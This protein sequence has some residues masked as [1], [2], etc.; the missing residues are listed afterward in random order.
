MPGIMA[1]DAPPLPILLIP[2]PRLRARTRPVGPVDAGK[3]RDLSDRMLDA[4]YKAPGIG[5]AA[6]QVGESLRLIVVD[7]QPDDTRQPYVM[8]NPEIVEA[9]REVALREEGCLSIPNQYA[10]VERPA[11]VKVRWQDL[12]GARREITAEG[13]MAACLQHEI[14]HLNGV[15]FIDH[16]SPLK[17]NMLLRR[18]NKDQKNRQRED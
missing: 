16:L 13:L 7:L 15:L 8:V 9:S 17:R 1:N 4:M 14:D 12:E 10:E 5:L 3:V 2:D 6:P 11:V 18:F